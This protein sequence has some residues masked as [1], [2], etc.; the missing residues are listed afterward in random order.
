[1]DASAIFFGM[2]S[3]IYFINN[4][5]V[6]VVDDVLFLQMIFETNVNIQYL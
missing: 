5:V 2:N 4:I 6:V 1:V 3:L